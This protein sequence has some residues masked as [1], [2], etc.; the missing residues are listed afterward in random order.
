M[1]E[2]DQA[3]S[4]SCLGG[5]SIWRPRRQNHT[6][7]ILNVL[8]FFANECI[9]QITQVTQQNRQS[10]ECRS[11]RNCRHLCPFRFELCACR[12]CTMS[13]WLP[14]NLPSIFSLGGTENAS[15]QKEKGFSCNFLSPKNLTAFYICDHFHIRGK[16]QMPLNYLFFFG[17]LH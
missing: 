9:H 11:V 8:I 4:W 16:F 6:P 7:Y 13:S 17:F 12:F 14:A 10:L 1:K 15:K 2:E 3:P 5:Q